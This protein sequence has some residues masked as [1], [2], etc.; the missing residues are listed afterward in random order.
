MPY[1]P[2][3]AMM[4]ADGARIARDGVEARA[5]LQDV[6]DAVPGRLGTQDCRR[7][8]GWVQAHSSFAYAL[9]RGGDRWGAEARIT[10]LGQ[11]NDASPAVPRRVLGGAPQP[12][13]WHRPLILA[14]RHATPPRYAAPAAQP[15]SPVSE[16]APPVASRTG[17]TGTLTTAKTVRAGFWQLACDTSKFGGLMRRAGATR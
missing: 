3:L 1:L 11:P 15:R 8:R 5:V 17:Y 9:W 13:P 10:A 14:V 16:P 2:D 6:K 4:L 12:E 7:M